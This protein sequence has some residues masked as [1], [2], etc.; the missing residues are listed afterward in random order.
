MN[1]TNYESNNKIQIIE[2]QKPRGRRQQGNDGS[3]R[4]YYYIT[5][6]NGQRTSGRMMRVVHCSTRSAAPS[7]HMTC[8]H[9]SLYTTVLSLFQQLLQPILD[10]LIK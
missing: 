10:L 1:N 9:P 7:P 2:D 3:G 5:A 6:M 8:R 4:K